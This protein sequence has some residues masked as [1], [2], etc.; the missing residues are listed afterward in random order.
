MDTTKAKQE[1]SDYLSKKKIPN[2]MVIAITK[3]I[4]RIGWNFEKD[5]VSVGDFG[6]A[7]H[8]SDGQYIIIEVVR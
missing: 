2:G 8:E 1:I 4:D 6:N 5:T 7:I 3:Y